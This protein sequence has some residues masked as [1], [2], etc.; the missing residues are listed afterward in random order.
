L[1]D[2]FRGG[3]PEAVTFRADVILEQG[4]NRSKGESV[5]GVCVCVCV[6]VCVRVG[7]C[8]VFVFVFVCVLCVCFL[9]AFWL[10]CVCFLVAFRSFS[11]CSPFTIHHNT[12]LPT[13][14]YPTLTTP[15]P[16]IQPHL[17]G[18]GIVEFDSPADAQF[19]IQTMHK[20]TLNDRE[21]FVREDRDRR[22]K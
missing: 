16:T 3:L 13:I 12:T 1:K 14:S 21:I 6:C 15:P 8:F 9:E 7:V 18:F 11:V 20:T 5:R 10:L 4:S 2:H 17:K 22:E 19:A